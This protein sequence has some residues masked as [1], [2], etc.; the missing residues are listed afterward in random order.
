[1]DCAPIQQRSRQRI[2]GFAPL[3]SVE[4]DIDLL[5]NIQPRLVILIHWDNF[6][7]ADKQRRLLTAKIP[8]A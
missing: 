8:V 5:R 7:P 6:S 1:V 3:Q 2:S 4:A